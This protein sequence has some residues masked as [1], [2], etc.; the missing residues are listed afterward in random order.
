MENKTKTLNY[1]KK[2]SD[3]ETNKQNERTVK[4][5]KNIKQDRNVKKKKIFKIKN[6]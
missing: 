1:S 2:K 3:Y 6:E 5:K 4:I